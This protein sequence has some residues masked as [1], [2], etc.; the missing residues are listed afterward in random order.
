M[1]YD[2]IIIGSGLAGLTCGIK[3]LK[4]G[5]SC[6]VITSGMSALHFASGSIDVFGYDDKKKIISN[7]FNHIEKLIRTD[8]N[9]PYAKCGVDNIREALFFFKDIAADEGIDFYNYHNKNYFHFTTLGALK[10]SYFFQQ[11]VCNENIRTLLENKAKI[12]V[13]NFEGYRDFYPEITIANLRKSKEFRDR[14][15]ITGELIYPNH[16]KIKRNLYEYRSI[17]I[18]RVFDNPEFMEDIGR[19]IKQIAADADI[20]C[21]PAFMGINNYRKHHEML[22]IISGKAVCEIPTPPPSLLGMRLDNALKSAF[23]SLGGVLVAGDK[24]NGAVI[25]NNAVEHLHTENYGDDALKA[26]FYVLASGSFFSGGLASDVDSIREPVFNLKVSYSHK[27]ADWSAAKLFD[28][29]SHAFLEYG[30][31]TNK[32]LNPLDS[33]GKAVKNLLCAGAIL[34]HYNPV[35][36]ASGGG[37]AVCTGY[38]A[39][40]NIVK[41]IKKK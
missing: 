5:L 18:A 6:A 8:K 38:M 31:E 30:V 33:T 25:N 17:D 40:K 28:R 37:V 34:A 20:V 16:K 23:A 27:R 13:L 35:K 41:G 14:E 12:A 19:Q 24:V 11:S 10:P 22:Q 26:R 39:A 4:E 9:H 1:N 7:P 15:F 29:K 2:C 36:E 3:C 21:L 32:S